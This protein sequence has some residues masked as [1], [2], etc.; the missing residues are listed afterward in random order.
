MTTLRMK[1]IAHATLALCVALAVCQPARAAED[2]A[3]M[4]H[5][6][7]NHGAPAKEAGDDMRG[8]DH[9]PG[10]A[11][12]MPPMQGGV[13]P[14]DA[15]DPHGYAGGYGHGGLPSHAMSDVAYWY[16]LMVDRLE[17]TQSRDNAFNAYELHT[18]FGKDY[19]RLLIKAEGEVD[20]G[21]LHEAR[22]E[23]LWSHAVAPYWNTQL[24]ARYDSGIAPHQKW[25]ALGVQGI[26]PY[27]F[28]VDVTGYVAAQRR[29]ALRLSAEYELLLTQRW[30]LQPRIE[31]NFYRKSDQDRG[32]GSGLT[33]LTTG[34][35]LRYEIRREFAPYV[36]VE[37]SGKFGGTADYA[38]AESE[39]AHETRLLAGLRFWF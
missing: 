8:M 36:G 26:A 6:S 4:D 33:S 11:M 17:S 34:L 27:W 15:R 16:G 2:M 24:G 28:E 32:L 12:E 38:R 13:T 23:V 10:N 18:W 25:L 37:W 20:S 5:S 31:A 35:R 14:A 19:N 7:M 9:A 22:N 29:M 21:Q 39:R 30:I 3:D 1:K